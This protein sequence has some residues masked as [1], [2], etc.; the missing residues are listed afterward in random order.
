MT[1][2]APTYQQL[3]RRVET[4]ERVLEQ[5]AQRAVVN[6]FASALMHEINNPLEAMINLVY[7][8]RRED[9]L[10]ERAQHRLQQLEGQL[11]ILTHVARSS[12]SFHRGQ[13]V[14]KDVDLISVAESALRLHVARIAERNVEVCRQFPER[15]VCQ[16]ISGELFQVVSN[17]ILN[18]LDALPEQTGASLHVR[19]HHGKGHVHLTV[20]DNGAGV[21]EHVHATLFEPHV[22]SK[23]NGTGLGLWLSERILD[24]HKGII[25]V[26]TSRTPGRS[27]TVFRVSLPHTTAA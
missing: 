4:M 24:R 6:Q 10:P 19:I 27:G 18:A 20:A 15:A 14:V 8:L 22:T 17:L 21:P 9:P 16:G 3:E 1:T 25:R 12:L 11:D 2:I 7:L 5:Y 26:R 23:R 13:E